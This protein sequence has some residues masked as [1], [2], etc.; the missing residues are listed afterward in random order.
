MLGRKEA[1]V[2]LPFAGQPVTYTITLSNVG[3]RL[4]ADNPGPEFYDILP[5]LVTLTSGV[6]SSGTLAVLLGSNTVA[7][8][9]SIPGGGSVTITLSAEIVPT[10]F[11]GQVV[12][13]QGTIL[14]DADANGTDESSV[15]TDTIRAPGRADPTVFTI[16]GPDTGPGIPALSA[17]GLAA[18]ALALAALAVDLLRR[19][20]QV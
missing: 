7:W 18:L 11:E 2:P 4:Q 16:Q 5:P 10:A 8:N 20:R 9:G 6:A 19:R 17:A 1:E 14:Y 3:T 15:L 12:S 13:N